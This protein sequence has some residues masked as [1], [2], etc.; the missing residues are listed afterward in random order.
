MKIANNRI[1][2]SN[3]KIITCAICVSN[4]NT[5]IDYNGENKWSR[6]QIN[7]R[8][9]NYCKQLKI[10]SP[11]DISPR[12][13]ENIGAKK[14]WIYPVMYK[15]IKKIEQGDRACK[16]IGVELIKE[17]NTMPFGRIL[18]SNTARAL[19]RTNL[20]CNLQK[21]LKNRIVTMLIEGKV[22]REYKEY[23]KLLRK[24]GIDKYDWQFIERYFPQDN[25]Y[26]MKYSNTK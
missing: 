8:Y 1:A 12:V 11:L 20:D 5:I 18:K 14:I 10:D 24:V 23:A 25:I 3:N 26:T 2:L 16:I 9:R 21:R 13:Y 6:E 7:L 19:R 22:P 15:V 4:K 17:N